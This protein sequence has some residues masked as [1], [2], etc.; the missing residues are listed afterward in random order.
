[1]EILRFGL[2]FGGVLLALISNLTSIDLSSR[3]LILFAGLVV[4]SLNK[5]NRL[6]LSFACISAT[7]TLLVFWFGGASVDPKAAAFI[8][9][10][11]LVSGSLRTAARNESTVQALGIK[12]ADSPQRY[13]FAVISFGIGLLSLVLLNG[14][15]QLVAGIFSKKSNAPLPQRLTITRAMIS[16][17]ALNPI[18]SPIAVPFVVMSSLL[19][20]VSWAPLA[21]Y[22][23][24]CATVVWVSGAFQ[25]RAT[26]NGTEARLDQPVSPEAAPFR[27]LLIAMLL[28]LA[29][30]AATIVLIFVIGLKPGQAAFTSIFLSSLAWPVLRLRQQHLIYSGYTVAINEAIVVGGSVFLGMLLVSYLP[31]GYSEAATQLLLASGSA[32]PAVILVFF[33]VGGM[34]GLQ[35]SICFLLIYALVPSIANTVG[36]SIVPVMAAM[37]VGWALNSVVTQFG[38]PVMIVSGAFKL[39]AHDF[40]YRYGFMF[41]LLSVIGC[42][43]VLSFG[44]MLL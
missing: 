28:V 23:F 17:F 19:P 44:S 3:A 4:L 27:S 20:S 12:L 36:D 35:P 31:S 10:F 30:I 11:L 5:L 13:R 29:P 32:A 9:A 40:A 21:P 33:V 1:M 34:F 26:S 41:L 37:I 22:L 38:I 7:A 14:S 2:A 6:A 42:A 25:A 24:A 16:G 8:F 39:R 15:L 18:L 43:A